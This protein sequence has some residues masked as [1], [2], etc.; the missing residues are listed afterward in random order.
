M[1][2]TLKNKLVFLKLLLV[3]LCTTNANAAIITVENTSILGYTD[4]YT[5]GAFDINSALGSSLYNLPYT[6]ASASL[7]FTFTDDTSNEI[8]TSIDSVN[9]LSK[10]Y[11]PNSSY[12]A[13][14]YEG[15]TRR[16]SNSFER[17]SLFAGGLSGGGTY[18]GQGESSRYSNETT[19]TTTNFLRNVYGGTGYSDPRAVRWYNTYN[20]QSTWRSWGN[21]SIYEGYREINSGYTG[22]F[23]IS[24]NLQQFL[25]DDLSQDG[26][27]NFEVRNSG[28]FNITGA[29]LTFEVTENPMK[30][31]PEPAILGIFGLALL[32]MRRFRRS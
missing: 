10:Y 5:R 6:I 29:S 16:I 7:S 11:R 18:L 13:R 32:A 20:G 19:R 15:K 12:D 2:N 25:L 22:S 17:A 27:L 4:S 24:A 26:I 3:T 1:R 30:E 8:S 31:V 28:D 9:S 21:V 14:I 23:S